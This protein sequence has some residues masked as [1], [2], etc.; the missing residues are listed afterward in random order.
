MAARSEESNVSQNDNLKDWSKAPLHNWSSHGAD[1]LRSFA[2]GFDD[3]TVSKPERRGGKGSRHHGVRSGQRSFSLIVFSSRGLKRPSFSLGVRYRITRQ[4]A[5]NLLLEAR[6][7]KRGIIVAHPQRFQTNRPSYRWNSAKR[8]CTPQSNGQ[9]AIMITKG[10]EG[11]RN[12]ARSISGSKN[13][14]DVVPFARAE[15]NS[16]A[17]QLD[18]AGQTILQLLHR[19]AGV[20]DENSRHALETAQKLSH[21]LR[22]AEDRIAELEAEVTA[23]RDRA[24]R[25]EQWLHRVYTEIEDRFLRQDDG[26]R[27]GQRA[28]GRSA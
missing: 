8:R 24:E 17:D 22:A 12:D 11:G 7:R 27:S 5:V 21:Q 1:A 14:S 9:T 2:C 20:A 4:C 28:V 13:D 23:H 6:Q 15:K 25:A 10:P 26:R 16:G 18:K 3:T 19:A